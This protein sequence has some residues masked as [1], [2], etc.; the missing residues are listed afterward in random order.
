[1]KA[2]ICVLLLSLVLF[3]GSGSNIV[4]A[5]EAIK[6]TYNKEDLQ[7]G[8]DIAKAALESTKKGDF[9]QAEKYW[10]ELIE[11]FP[12]NPA[13]WSNR[14]NS[15]IS[16]NRLEEAITDF[17]QAIT[18]APDAPD[19][20]LNRGTAL[21]GTGNYLKAIQDYNRVLELNPDD[22][23]A[24]NNRGNAQGGLGKWKLA[25]ADYQKAIELEPNFAL[26]RANDSLALYQLG[27]TEEALKTMRN[28]VRKY[29]MF[30]DARAALTA[31]LWE[32]GLQGEAES[33]W[34]AAVEMDARYQDLNWVNHVRRWPPEM[35][36]ALDRFINLN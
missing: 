16:Q 28:L 23:M 2:W 7:K 14:G 30:P 29:P 10:T 12:D 32:E 21:E 3:L 22:A 8:D 17:N 34:V 24:Y 6:F 35:V 31:V 18:L 11:K 27:R 33:N 15:R 9:V 13:V 25:L 26:A 1:M 36:S 4:L 20:Y 5:Q 19:A